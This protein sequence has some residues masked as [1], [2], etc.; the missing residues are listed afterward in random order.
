MDVFKSVFE[1][2]FNT[3]ILFHPV[4]VVDWVFKTNR[5]LGDTHLSQ[6]GICLLHEVKNLAELLAYGISQTSLN[7]TLTI[8][9]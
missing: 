7:D 2:M 6:Q 3:F 1:V 9:H 5:S 8:V 4:Q